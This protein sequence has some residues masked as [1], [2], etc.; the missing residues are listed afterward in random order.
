[1]MSVSKRK[2]GCKRMPLDSTHAK[3]GISLRMQPVQTLAKNN[4]TGYYCYYYKTFGN[5][6]EVQVYVS[7]LL[8]LSSLF[9]LLFKIPHGNNSRLFR[10]IPIWLSISWNT[11]KVTPGSHAWRASLYGGSPYIGKKKPDLFWQPHRALQ[12]K[13]LFCTVLHERLIWRHSCEGPSTDIM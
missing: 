5:P 7:N 11:Y 13:F 1:M 6:L 8:Q 10:P 2:K 4:V 9:S 3:V 12:H